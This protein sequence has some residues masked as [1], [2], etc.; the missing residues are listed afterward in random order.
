MWK[1]QSN[2]FSYSQCLL[3]FQPIKYAF[4]TS[5]PQLCPTPGPFL[6]SAWLE[7]LQGIKATAKRLQS[8]CYQH[9]GFFTAHFW[10]SSITEHYWWYSSFTA[11]SWNNAIWFMCIL[12]TAMLLLPSFQKHIT[13]LEQHTTVLQVLWIYFKTQEGKSRRSHLN[14]SFLNS[15]LKCCTRHCWGKEILYMTIKIIYSLKYQLA[16]LANNFIFTLIQPKIHWW[17]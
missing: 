1:F 10:K 4:N 14:N 6:R 7:K 11:Q 16:S 8:K 2:I 12:K 3:L 13:E 17:P 15:C 9:K 5:Q